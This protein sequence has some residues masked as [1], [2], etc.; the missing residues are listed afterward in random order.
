MDILVA[1]RQEEAKWEKQ[2]EEARQ[3]L[4]TVRAAMKLFRGE[5]GKR[6]SG[7]GRSGKAT[8][9]RSAKTTSGKKRVMSA[10]ARARISK[11]SKERWAKFRAAKAKGK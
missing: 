1:L 5:T 8:G 10:A 11:A 9:S 7:L 3:Q 4:E 2:A 6:I